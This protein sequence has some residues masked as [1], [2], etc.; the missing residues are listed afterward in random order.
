MKTGDYVYIIHNDKRL[1]TS[2][3]THIY[4][5]RAQLTAGFSVSTKTKTGMFFNK[6]MRVEIVPDDQ[7][8]ELRRRGL[9]IESLRQVARGL[10]SMLKHLAEDPFADFNERWFRRHLQ[11]S[12]CLIGIEHIEQ[13]RKKYIERR[14]SGEHGCGDAPI[15]IIQD[16]PFEVRDDQYLDC[17]EE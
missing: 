3:V 12:L 4:H 15:G 1:H 17:E 6:K 5:G 9:L 8:R 14:I 13:D 2:M 11:E 16:Y 7:L 10:N